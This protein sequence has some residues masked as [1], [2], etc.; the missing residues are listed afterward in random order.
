M[1]Q[2]L[3]VMRVRQ[4]RAGGGVTFVPDYL[5]RSVEDV[6]AALF[7]YEKSPPLCVEFSGI[8]PAQH[9]S[10]LTWFRIPKRYQNPLN[11]DK[12][13]HW[14]RVAY[15]AH[16]T[17]W[18]GEVVLDV[19]LEDKVGAY[20]RRSVCDCV[21]KQQCCD[22]C[23][24]VFM[25]SAQMVL[26]HL[27]H[28]FGIRAFFFCFSG[29]RGLHCWIVDKNVVLWTQEQRL[30]FAKKLESLWQEDT[31][32][33]DSIYELLEPVYEQHLASTR[34]IAPGN[35]RLLR[36]SRKRAVLEALYP[37]L[38][39]PVSADAT[40][41]HKLPLMIH[42]GTDRLCVVFEGEFVPSENAYDVH[43]VTREIL[44]EG[45]RIIS[46]ALDRGGWKM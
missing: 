13:R 43:N 8:C 28:S 14:D 36:E 19:D 41:N 35:A 9:V 25:H 44:E 15:R 18:L 30:C 40:H 20:D 3:I 6:R 17:A 38:D 4:R 31:P 46:K 21:G 39:V 34:W 29:R 10:N 1:E 22:V 7:L 24:K 23:W 27:L 26:T 42:P 11:P 12:P 5:L 37:K 45:G 33:T 32:L 2:R 16:T